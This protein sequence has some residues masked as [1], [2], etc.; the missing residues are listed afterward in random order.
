MQVKR[1]PSMTGDLCESLEH[2][3]VFSTFTVVNAS[4]DGFGSLRQAVVDANLAGTG[5][6]QIRFR[7]DSFDRVVDNI[8]LVVARLLAAAVIVIVLEHN[9]VG[10][11]RQPL[12]R[13]LPSPEFGRRRELAEREILLDLAAGARAIVKHKPVAIGREDERN[14][15]R[16]G[17]LQALLHAV[18]D[19]A[20]EV[21]S[22]AANT[23][24]KPV[25]LLLHVI[26][27]LLNVSAT[28]QL[29]VIL[30]IVER[31]SVRD[32]ANSQRK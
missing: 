32:E 11:R 5:D 14:P 29:S 20:I 24:S 16:R 7:A 31:G 23:N 2:R 10:F 9:C 25:R 22:A 12:P 28:R 3:L 30:P 15:E 8:D 13:T 26:G 18:T 1:R 4:G 6:D 19:T 21:G 27:D 17:I